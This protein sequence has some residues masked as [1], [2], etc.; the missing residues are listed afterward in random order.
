MLRCLEGVLPAVLRAGLRVQ[1]AGPCGLLATQRHWGSAAGPA[2]VGGNKEPETPLGRH[3]KGIVRF[4]DGPITVAEYMQASTRS[5][6][7]AAAPPPPPARDGCSR[8]RTQE[9]LT[10]PAKGYYMHR[11]VFGRRGDFVTASG[12]CGL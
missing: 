12:R 9:V 4:G 7:N 1:T 8:P 5:P 11:D 3:L 6:I 10:G 2:H